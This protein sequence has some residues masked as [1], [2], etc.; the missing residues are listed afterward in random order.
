MLTGILVC[1]KC[2]YPMYRHHSKTK[3]K[4]GTFSV[5]SV[6]RCK[7]ADTSPSRCGN[8]IPLGYIEEWVNA[9]FTKNGTFARTEIVETITVPGD[10]HALDIAEI[11]TDLRDLDFDA[12]DFAE[13]QKILLSSGRGCALCRPNPPK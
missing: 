13:Q 12:P 7:G 11:E 8:A 3:R 4:D 2:G 10:D 9:W 6:Y 5:Y 1:E